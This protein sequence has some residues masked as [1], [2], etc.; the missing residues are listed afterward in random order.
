[1]IENVLVDLTPKQFVDYLAVAGDKVDNI[2]GVY[3]VG[4]MT[5][6]PL[7]Q[8]YGSLDGIYNA[9]QKAVDTKQLAE[10]WKTEFG[11]KKNPIKAFIKDKDNAY[12]SRRLATI[13]TDIEFLPKEPCAYDLSLNKSGLTQIIHEY[14]F[15]SLKNF[16]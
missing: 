6:I 5:I 7:L 16:L 15:A 12:L 8:K 9:I 10:Q 13:K 3:G 2:P 11:I 1:M 4:A 14:E